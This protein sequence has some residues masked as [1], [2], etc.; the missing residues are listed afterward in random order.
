MISLTDDEL[1]VVLD[2]ARPL[3]PKDR[4]QFLRD[5]ACGRHAKIDANDPEPVIGRTER[6]LVQSLA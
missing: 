2:A 1:Q 4:D 3:A 6:Q 5:V